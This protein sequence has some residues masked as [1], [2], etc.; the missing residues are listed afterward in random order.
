MARKKKVPS[1]RDARRIR[2]QQIIF[3]VIAV[4]VIIVMLIG[5]IAK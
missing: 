2:T 5:L 3:A 1:A 4:M